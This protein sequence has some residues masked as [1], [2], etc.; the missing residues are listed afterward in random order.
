MGA[1]LWLGLRKPISIQIEQVVIR[2][3]PRPW[4]VV[5]CAVHIGVRYR[6]SCHFEMMDKTIP[7]IRILYRHQNS[8]RLLHGRLSNGVISAG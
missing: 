3:A 7:P 1:Y 6:A 4:F 5:L 2:S 8:N